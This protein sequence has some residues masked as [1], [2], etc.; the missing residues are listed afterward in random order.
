[1]LWRCLLHLKD[2][3][4]NRN[5]LKDCSLQSLLMELICFV[6]TGLKKSHTETHTPTRWAALCHPPRA[7]IMSQLLIPL[8]IITTHTEPTPSLSGNNNVSSLVR[9]LSWI[10]YTA[11]STD[12]STYFVWYL[13]VG[14]SPDDDR[15]VS[16]NALRQQSVH[17][18]QCVCVHVCVRESLTCMK[19]VSG[20]RRH[21]GPF[22]WQIPPDSL[23]W[24]PTCHHTFLQVIL[25]IYCFTKTHP[26]TFGGVCLCYMTRRTV[27][28]W[29]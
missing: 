18:T 25:L 1:M 15:P 29:T 2:L 21:N 28:V 16:A 10:N 8:K 23:T 17:W 27:L 3:T 4:C 11:A 14:A 12:T 24:F 19:W 5:R 6:T 22:Q 20:E 9:P 13:E 7:R 26:V